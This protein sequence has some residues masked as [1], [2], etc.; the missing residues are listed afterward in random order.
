MDTLF[1]WEW[2]I[3]ELMVLGFL[4]WEYIKTRKLIRESRERRAR[5]ARGE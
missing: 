5:E 1:Q 4:V 2:L 3:I